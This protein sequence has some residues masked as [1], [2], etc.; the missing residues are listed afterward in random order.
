MWSS[1]LCDTAVV[2][3]ES[4]R[5]QRPVAFGEASS[6]CPPCCCD[7]L[8]FT[9]F[10]WVDL[11]VVWLQFFRSRSRPSLSPA[12]ATDDRAISQ[13]RGGRGRGNNS[14]DADGAG[15]GESSRR[16][17]K[18][19][20][21][22]QKAKK[23]EQ[24]KAKRENSSK[25]SRSD[26]QRKK[27]KRKTPT[28]SKVAR[29]QGEGYDSSSSGSS[30]NSKRSRSDKSEEEHDAISAEVRVVVTTERA[31]EGPSSAV[32]NEDAPTPPGSLEPRKDTQTHGVP[33]TATAGPANVGTGVNEPCVDEDAPTPP[34]SPSRPHAAVKVP[35]STA[36]GKNSF[37]AQLHAMER[38]KGTVGTM[39]ATGGGGGSGGGG[40]PIQS[41]DWECLKCGKSN[42]KN[43]SACDRY[44]TKNSKLLSPVLCVIGLYVSN[45]MPVRVFEG[46]RGGVV[47]PIIK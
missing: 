44:T 22:E 39:H 33:S 12:R 23:R 43:A 31:A 10:D 30:S 4:F 27:K 28:N 45:K 16:R 19:K 32:V 47:A 20:K 2:R 34:A 1:D 5:V 42:Y 17:K 40:G 41:S 13:N 8:H 24:K 14:D 9:V 11:Y 15:G 36:V 46:L 38:K 7:L 3:I 26:R 35:I 25:S 21:E 6:F 18:Q 29:Q 37:F